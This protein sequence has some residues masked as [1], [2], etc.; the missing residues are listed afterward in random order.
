MAADAWRVQ[1]L[2]QHRTQRPRLRPHTGLQ[3]HTGWSWT[4]LA[5]RWATVAARSRLCA[6][7]LSRQFDDTNEWAWHLSLSS[8]LEGA[9]MSDTPAFSLT[10]SR[11]VL[12]ACT[13]NTTRHPPPPGS[14]SKV[15]APPRDDVMRADHTDSR[16]DWAPGQRGCLGRNGRN[17]EAGMAAAASCAAPA[18]QH[19]HTTAWADAAGNA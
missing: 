18:H 19:H 5:R 1:Q 2:Q 12:H 9:P 17:G 6:A 15:P 14:P 4:W 10:A 11:P 7:G 16:R 8:C 3:S 13:L